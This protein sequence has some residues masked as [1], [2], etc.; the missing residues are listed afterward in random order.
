[1]LSE[2]VALVPYQMIGEWVGSWI[3]G[4]REDRHF[5]DRELRLY[6]KT[7]HLIEG[8]FERF[9][10]DRQTIF[11]SAKSSTQGVPVSNLLYVDL[12]TVGAPAKLND[13]SFAGISHTLRDFPQPFIG[14]DGS[15]DLVFVHGEGSR[16]YAEHREFQRKNGERN[17][18]TTKV[19]R[20]GDFEYFAPLSMTL[21]F[22]ACKINPKRDMPRFPIAKQGLRVDD[23]DFQHNIITIGSGAVN[24]FSRRVLEIYDD[25]LPIRFK[26]PDSDEEIIDQSSSEA[27]TFSRRIES[28]WNTGLI[29]LFPNPFCPTKIILIAAGLTVTGTQAALHALCDAASKKVLSDRLSAS[30]DG[31]MTIPAQLVR[32]TDITYKSGLESAGGY[33]F[34]D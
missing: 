18:P 28:E 8:R 6:L 34:V 15:L 16:D 14:A 31:T 10:N 4:N 33:E 9:S 1:M 26:K 22:A 11:V 5:K 21:G 12:Q 19:G 3:Q 13:Y 7:G 32:A 27:R 25:G 23:A 17:L 30:V 29:E 20:R 24:T 2:L